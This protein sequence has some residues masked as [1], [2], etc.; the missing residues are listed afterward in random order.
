[1]KNTKLLVLVLLVALMACLSVTALAAC[2]PVAGTH[3]GTAILDT[4]QSKAATCVTEGYIVYSCSNCGTIM[5]RT[6]LP[7]TGTHIPDAWWNPNEATQKA[8]QDIKEVQL[9]KYFD[10]CGHVFTDAAHT[11]IRPA[12]K[13]HTWTTVPGVEATCTADGKKPLDKCS[14]CGI[15]RGNQNDGSVIKA[16]GH[17]YD[18]DAYPDEQPVPATCANTGINVYYCVVCHGAAKKVT[19]PKLTYHVDAALKP[20]TVADYIMANPKLE[21]TCLNDGCEAVYVCPT[22]GAHDP[23]R[24]GQKIAAKGHQF[25]ILE[26]K[27]PTCTAKGYTMWECQR[28]WDLGNGPIKCGHILYEEQAA[29][30]HSA[31]WTPASVAADGTYTVWELRCG[32]CTGD[33]GKPTV[34]AMQI[35]RKGDKAPSGTVNTGSTAKNDKV[36][37]TKSGT[38][39]VAKKTTT[40]KTTTAKKTTTTAKA[41][42]TTAKAAPAATAVAVEGTK[43]VEGLN[44]I[45][46]KAVVVAKEGKA[47][48]VYVEE[49]FEVTLGEEVLVLGEAV[50][51]A[52]DDLAS[53]AEAPAAAASK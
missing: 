19:V 39:T 17:V 21:A 52:A 47:T 2:D 44:L 30:G 27:L 26:T 32:R 18:Y 36:T 7:A 49:G 9:C 50:A 29:Y 13:D 14:V 48:L 5:T 40:T 34:L 45:D 12:E 23:A 28:T 8:C 4:V 11:R 15:A 1:M 25:V 35:V 16:F 42:T 43:L 3:D 51:Y 37:T 10:V 20:I 6:V 22:C 46:N 31:T 41:A 38:T 53:V 33:D 24:N